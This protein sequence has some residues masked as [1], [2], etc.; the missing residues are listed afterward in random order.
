MFKTFIN[1]NLE[2]ARYWVQQYNSK[3]CE[4]TLTEFNVLM[5]AFEYAE[6]LVSNGYNSSY[7]TIYSEEL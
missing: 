6:V 4:I 5:D 1:Y 3:T 2:M 7:I